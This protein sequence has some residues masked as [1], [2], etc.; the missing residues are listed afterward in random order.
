MAREDPPTRF[1]PF[2]RVVVELF[3]SRE[4]EK[5]KKKKEKKKV[6]Y[7]SQERIL[8]NSGPIRQTG[9]LDVVRLWSVN[10]NC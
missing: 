8:N 2:H 1:V 10:G 9:D 7:S 6:E 3:L 4:R 5:K